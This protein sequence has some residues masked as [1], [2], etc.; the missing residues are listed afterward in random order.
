M[1]EAGQGHKDQ[2][3]TTTLIRNCRFAVVWDD[4]AQSHVYR[5][6]VDVVMAKDRIA[7]IGEN[8]SGESDRVI[9]GANFLVMPGSDRHSLASV[10][11]ADEQGHVG[12]GR[13]AKLYN[14]S[15]Y[16]YLPILNPDEEGVKAS[17]GVALS[18]VLIGGHHRSRPLAAVEGRLDF[19]GLGSR[20]SVAPTFRSGRRFTL[21]G[22][23]WNT[24]LMND[25]ATRLSRGAARDRQGVGG[26]PGGCLTG[27]D[28]PDKVHRIEGLL[29]DVFSERERR[30]LPD[31]THAAQLLA[32]FH[33]IVRLHSGKTP[34]RWLNSLCVLRAPS[35]VTPFSPTITW[36]HWPRTMISV[37][38]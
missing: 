4:E 13:K 36:M 25:A 14:T 29:R 19:R 6:G 23:S 17:Y 32:E 9:D 7:F 12:R 28:R 31:Q 22:S 37:S 26:H 15:L 2:D 34:I 3:V 21:N 18:E 38:A 30:S 24:I 8:Y 5:S 33:E 35:S 16:E 27:N 20:V 1:T 10:Q 11:R